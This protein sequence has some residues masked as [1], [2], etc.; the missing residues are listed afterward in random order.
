MYAL[1]YLGEDA[2]PPQGEY[3]GILALG[4]DGILRVVPSVDG[5]GQD[6]IRGRHTST[7]V[8]G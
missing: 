7:S 5:R 8:A 6:L 4:G 2:V 3:D 1:E